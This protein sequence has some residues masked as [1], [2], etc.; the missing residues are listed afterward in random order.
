MATPTER[1]RLAPISFDTASI[2]VDDEQDYR[3]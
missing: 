3:S 1:F 2:A